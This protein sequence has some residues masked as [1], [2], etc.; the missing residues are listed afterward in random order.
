M[1]ATLQVHDVLL[2]DK[3]A[4]RLSSPH[5]GDIAVFEPPVPS[6]DDFIKRV[7]GVPGD[8]VEVHNGTLYRNGKAVNE[9]YAKHADYTFTIANYDFVV[10]GV[11]LSPDVANIPPRSAWTSPDRLPAN[12]YLMFGD[13][14]NDSMDS[15]FWGCAQ[16]SGTFASGQRKGAP[17][18]FTGR[19]D[20]LVL[21]LSRLRLLDRPVNDTTT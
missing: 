21:P 14:R 6:P 16:T 3:F 15:H 10:D 13:N 4:Y 7:V 11:P 8:H 9:P 2:V 5:D 18:H 12:C 1:A 20:L 17:A 19:A